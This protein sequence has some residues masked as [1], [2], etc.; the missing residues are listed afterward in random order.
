[1]VGLFIALIQTVSFGHRVSRGRRQA[2][3]TLSTRRP[4]DSGSCLCSGPRRR[5]GVD[6]LTDRELSPNGPWKR[7]RC[8]DS[9]SAGIDWAE[10]R[11]DA[12][13]GRILGLE[14]LALC[15][16]AVLEI[17]S[18]GGVLHSGGLCAGG[19]AADQFGSRYAKKY[20]VI[21]LLFGR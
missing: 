3:L 5:S 12:K 18:R 17:S 2:A 4:P 10:E 6:L 14:R 20:G 8:L 15:L 21:I 9:V 7:R 11:E 19:L 16:R 1:M 13:R